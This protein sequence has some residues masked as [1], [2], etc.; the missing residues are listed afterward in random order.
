M[1]SCV[2]VPERHR[3]QAWNWDVIVKYLALGYN[4]DMHAE[5][6]K[7]EKYDSPAA[8]TEKGYKTFWGK[9]GDD[10]KSKY[11]PDP[12]YSDDIYRFIDREG[13]YR[14]P[15][16][17][18][19]LSNVTK[20]P[21]PHQQGKLGEFITNGAGMLLEKAWSEYEAEL[22]VLLNAMETGIP[23]V[24][25]KWIQNEVQDELENLKG[26]KKEEKK[27]EDDDTTPQPD[28]QTRFKK[29]TEEWRT[30]GGS[31]R[32]STAFLRHV[33]PQYITIYLCGLEDGSCILKDFKRSKMSRQS[34]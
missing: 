25:F 13:N 22:Y 23:D 31:F 7:A 28:E 14:E 5:K 11:L 1:S 18:L 33:P 15:P 21:N 19:N 17:P 20:E 9:N 30:T 29:S 24:G 27:E 6:S 16:L 3:K 12:D 8:F 26:E 10:V 32:I 34:S 4:E 2:L